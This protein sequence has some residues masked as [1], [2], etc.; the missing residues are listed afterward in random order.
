MKLN[1]NMSRGALRTLL[2]MFSLLIISSTL[3]YFGS[4]GDATTIAK[5]IKSGVLTADTVDVSFENVGGVLLKRDI[6]ESQIVK[7]GDVLMVLDD[8]DTAI[9][10]ERTKATI[11]AQKALILSKENEIEIRKANVDLEE[12]TKWKEI[13]QLKQSLTV[14]ESAKLLAQKQYKRANS[15]VNTRSISKSDYDSANSQ[16]IQAGAAKT[17]ALRKLQAAIYGATDEQIEKLKRTG[18]AKGMTLLSIKNER[19]EIDN[20]QNALDNLKSQLKQTEVQLKQEEVNYSRLTLI[21]PCDG[22]ILKILYQQG[23]LVSPNSSGLT[24][25]T[26]RKYF[27]IYVSEEQVLKYKKGNKVKVHCVATDEDLTGTVRYATV[28][29]TFADLRMTRER[30]LGDLTSFQVRI[31]VDSPEV[32]T[33]MTMEV[34]DE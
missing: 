14:S 9:S 7:K 10:I 13:E 15:L 3:I 11:E 17:Q 18:S 19:L 4:R 5:S 21:A 29:P 6:E 20:M 30:G 26:D 1:S 25:E 12:L 33:G 24:L 22:K 16:N 28:A 23:E 31:Y 27:D 32:L 8:T 34:R 2:T